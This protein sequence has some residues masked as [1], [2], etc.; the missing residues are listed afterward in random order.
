M[1]N[2][3]FY[4][5]GY[6]TLEI[7]YYYDIHQVMGYSLK[8]LYYIYCWIL[9]RS[10]CLQKQVLC[11]GLSYTSEHLWWV[12]GSNERKP[13][14]LIYIFKNAHQG[15]FRAKFRVLASIRISQQ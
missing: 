5:C 8:G 13:D 7:L 15:G 11:N 4:D 10:L 3:Q 12:T 14:H 2:Y 6:P 9:Q 1:N